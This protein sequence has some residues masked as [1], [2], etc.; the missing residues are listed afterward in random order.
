MKYASGILLGLLYC[1]ELTAQ[2]HATATATGQ[3]DSATFSVNKGMSKFLESSKADPSTSIQQYTTSGSKLV[4]DKYEFLTQVP[5]DAM[6]SGYKNKPKPPPP[7]A[8]KP[9]PSVCMCG[10]GVNGKLLQQPQSLESGV[11]QK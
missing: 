11:Q 3:W 5:Q 2:Q 8:P 9:L 1:S 10:P 7:P 4:Q 6:S